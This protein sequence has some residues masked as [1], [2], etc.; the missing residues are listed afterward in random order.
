MRLIRLN[1]I[2]Q[3]VPG[4]TAGSGGRTLDAPSG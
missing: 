2:A 3:H 4:E 1:V